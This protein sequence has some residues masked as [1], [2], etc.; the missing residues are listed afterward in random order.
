[1]KSETRVPEHSVATWR[2]PFPHSLGA[3]L[4]GA[5]VAA[6]VGT[7]LLRV[8]GLLTS[9]G[10]SLGM[11]QYDLVTS[12]IQGAIWSVVLGPI[13]YFKGSRSLLPLILVPTIAYAIVAIAPIAATASRSDAALLY[14]SFLAT[15]VVG[16]LIGLSSFYSSVLVARKLEAME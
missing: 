5:F 1:M 3:V 9:Y 13:V 12:A 8:F 15:P 6:F 14:P 10:G 7:T 4:A 2:L 16:F 11:A